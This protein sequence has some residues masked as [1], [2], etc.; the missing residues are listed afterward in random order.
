MGSELITYGLLASIFIVTGL[1]MFIEKPQSGTRSC[2]AAVARF[3]AAQRAA[4]RV[5][6][7][8]IRYDTDR[9]AAAALFLPSAGR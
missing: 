9:G 7:F 2:R 6:R 8:L 3:E 1:R 4:Q 5:D